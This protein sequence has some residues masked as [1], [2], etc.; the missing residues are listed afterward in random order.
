MAAVTATNLRSTVRFKRDGASN[1]FQDKLRV[2]RPIS[3]ILTAFISTEH[4]WIWQPTL[5]RTAAMSK[6]G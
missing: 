6:V 4:K 5:S 2:P 1:H 3:T